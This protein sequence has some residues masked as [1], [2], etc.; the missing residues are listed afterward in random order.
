MLPNAYQCVV[1]VGRPCC[2]ARETMRSTENILHIHHEV[3]GISVQF[4][5][6]HLELLTPPFLHPVVPDTKHVV[7]PWSS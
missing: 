7:F 2:F 6:F 4:V 1:D 3:S 5:G